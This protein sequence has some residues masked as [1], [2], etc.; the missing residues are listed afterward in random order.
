[1]AL[2]REDAPGL[3]VAIVAC[4]VVGAAPAFVTA[5]GSD[6]WY[7]SL[8]D[9]A[10][11]PPNWV[12]A[13]VWTT[14]FVLM[15]VAAYIVY[16]G[17]VGRERTTAL[18][19]FVVQFAFNVAWT[20]VFFGSESIAGGLAVIAVLWI[21][22]AARLVAFWRVRRTAGLLLVPYLAWVSFATYLN[23]AFWALN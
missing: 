7:R 10:L 3:L 16:Q 4:N 19:L 8:A 15:G 2:S 12:F 21:L 18:A 22:I 5:T 17:G 13:P 23:Y 6:S 14:L 20:L 11:A 9:P 1:M